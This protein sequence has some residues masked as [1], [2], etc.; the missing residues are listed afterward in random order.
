MAEIQDTEQGVVR[1]GQGIVHSAFQRY[2]VS[3]LI[4]S[5]YQNLYTT[6]IMQRYPNPQGK[7]LDHAHGLEEEPCQTRK[8]KLKP[9][10]FFEEISSMLKNV[11]QEMLNLACAKN[12]PAKNSMSK[13]SN[14]ASEVIGHIGWEVKLLKIES[15][16]NSIYGSLPIYSSP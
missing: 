5:A 4:K 6:K 15:S 1:P 8:H 2:M 14:L 16:K 10:K 12:R 11:Q 9:R 13:N 3:L 7:N